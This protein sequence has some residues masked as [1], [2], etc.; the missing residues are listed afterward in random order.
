MQGI[1]PA[2]ER[3]STQSP[4]EETWMR[5]GAEGVQGG[6]L[7]RRRGRDGHAGLG[8]AGLWREGHRASNMDFGFS[9]VGFGML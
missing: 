2:L 4:L 7:R 8:G 3:E 1:V 5:P 6:A 9:L